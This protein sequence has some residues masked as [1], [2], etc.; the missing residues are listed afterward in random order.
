MNSR[1]RFRATFDF[2][3]TD[4]PFYWETP[5]AWGAT[6]QRWKKE[7]FSKPAGVKFPDFF[8][9]DKISW[10][11]IK[12]GWVG[13]PYYPMFEETEL[14]DDGTNI[15]KVDRYG[16]TK[17]IRKFNPETSMPQFLEFP[18]KKRDDFINLIQPKLNFT[19]NGRFPENWDTLIK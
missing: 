14:A 6:I 13:N 8:G 2:K 18:V 1:E 11:P 5:G 7:G 9:M 15:T 17:K 3:E 4:R 12:G 19:D 10:L 16:I